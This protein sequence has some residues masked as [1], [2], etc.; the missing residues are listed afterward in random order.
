MNENKS[1]SQGP[2][3]SNQNGIEPDNQEVADLIPAFAFGATDGDEADL[4]RALLSKE[5]E[6]AEEVA[7]YSKLKEQLLFAVPLAEPPAT[8]TASL[9]AAI[10]TSPAAAVPENALPRS[11]RLF[12]WWHMPQIWQGSLTWGAVCTMLILLLLMNRYWSQQVA[13]LRQTQDALEAELLMHQTAFS[14]I[15][16]DDTERIVLKPTNAADHLDADLIWGEGFEVALLY[17]ADFPDAGEGKT[18]QAWLV[19]EGR[20][21]DAG[22]FAVN[23]F[24]T[25]TLFV[26]LAQTFDYYDHVQITIEPAGGSNQPTTSPIAEGATRDSV[27]AHE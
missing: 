16:M 4:V 25:G 23:N 24:G 17:V 19:H 3:S 7:A 18:Y 9:Q 11:K 21:T 10:R 5:P 27:P 12:S 1:S 6:L 14:V 26:R 20:Y 8:L 22:T 15:A 13:T 2:S